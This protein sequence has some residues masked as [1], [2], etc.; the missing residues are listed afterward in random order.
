MKKLRITLLREAGIDPTVSKL[1]GIGETEKRLKAAGKKKED[2]AAIMYTL[3]VKPP[4][5]PRIVV[6]SDP[7]PAIDITQVNLLEDLD[8][9]GD[10]GEV[11]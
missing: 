3:T 4:G 10:K 6:E 9:P 7:N 5:R 1:V 11:L 8:V 2:V